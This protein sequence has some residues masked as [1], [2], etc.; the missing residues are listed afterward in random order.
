MI[1]QNFNKIFSISGFSFLTKLH[2]GNFAAINMNNLLKVYSGLKPF[3]CLNQTKIISKGTDIYNIKEIFVSNDDK[4][5]YIILYEK[6]ILIYFFDNSYK[7]GTLLIK[8]KNEIYIQTLMQLNNKNC[9]F[10]DK[11]NK[12]RYIQFNNDNKKKYFINK[13]NT[14]KINNKDN[15]KFI[16]SF[17]EFQN[18]HI[19]TTSTSK[20]P[21]GEN[22]IRIYEIKFN[23]DKSKLINYQNF[24]GYS[25]AAF[26]NNIC[27][28]DNQKTICIAINFYFKKD[29]QINN[30]AIILLNYEYL[31]ITTIIEIEFQINTIF[32]FS[33]ISFKGNYKNIYEYLLISQLKENNNDNKIK[34]KSKDNFRFIDFFVFEPKN[35]YEPLLLEG[36]SIVTNNPIDITNS[37]LLNNKNLVIFQ[38]TQINIYEIF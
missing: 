37:F 31:E 17:I 28:L 25:C 33:N 2:D 34:K 11:G 29:I 36:K 6:D 38:T 20:H 15:N 26:E 14:F 27:K 13:I 18:N 1:K 12:I 4:K 35:E 19:I 24:N 30:N 32:N 7:K 10:F 8:I 3:N 16:L 21:N 22:I 9:I 5:I 23:S